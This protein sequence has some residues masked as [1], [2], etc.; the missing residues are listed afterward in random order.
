[1]VSELVCA[2]PYVLILIWQQNIQT[3]MGRISDATDLGR[4]LLPYLNWSKPEITLA[5]LQACIALTVG[6]AFLLNAIP[7]RYVFLVAG[8]SALFTNHPIVKDL[9]ADQQ[10]WIDHA[11]ATYTRAGKRWLKDNQL[12]DAALDNP[13]VEVITIEEER[14]SVDNLWIDHR[15]VDESGAVAP[16]LGQNL[17]RSPPEGCDWLP[18]EGWFVD[19]LVVGVDAGK[20]SSVTAL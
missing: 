11:L 18:D 5:L 4:N 15:L 12:P 6:M 2:L 17:Q 7:W 3:M 10:V 8:E 9:I 20:S 19:P 16:N 14:L 13:L 1:M